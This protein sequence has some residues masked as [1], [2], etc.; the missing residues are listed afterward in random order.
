MIQ[1]GPT[2]VNVLTC[3]GVFGDGVRD[4]APGLQAALDSGAAV[5]HLPRP[6]AHYEVRRTLRLHSGQTLIAERQTVIRLAD[7][8]DTVLL[9]N[10]DQETG[11]RDVTVIGGVWDGNHAH[12][13][14][15]GAWARDQRYDPD[16]F[17]GVLV[18]FNRVCNLTVRELTLKDPE[19]FGMQLGNLH[20][21]TITDL[22]FDYN[23][24]R[25]NMDGVHLHGH[26]Y[27]GRIANLRGT[28]NDDLV[29][30]NADDGGM[31]EM[32]RGP[33][34]DITVD[35]LYS[36]NG[37]TGVRLLSAGSPV[38]RVRL[39]NV[40]GT[41]RYNVVSFTHHNVHPGAPSVFEDI[42][43]DGV[44]CAKPTAALP[45]PLPGDEWGRTSTPLIW[46][47][48]GTY[49]HN[50]SISR[51]YRTEAFARAPDTVVVDP[52][53]T[54]ERL[55]LSDVSQ[56]NRT[57]GPLTVLTNRGTIKVLQMTDVAATAVG[58][59]ARGAILRN[60]GVIGHQ[61]LCGLAGENLE[62]LTVE[63]PVASH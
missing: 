37:Y 58:G 62:A 17:I 38:R 55:R 21:F 12:Q 51:L 46:F 35:G 18:R 3:P 36:E 52:G 11:N 34:E 10:A 61:S 27:Q 59:V 49:C 6:A 33:I 24:A 29:A 28:T 1:V 47:A 25:A 60:E 2:A 48:A 63:S 31:Y 19:T 54:V 7:G 39:S 20:G 45:Q 56:L 53:A 13:S 57:P 30:L 43:I 5:V 14:P 15:H 23:L 9:A 16:Q 44:F 22:V 8:A 40:F 41:F 4:D 42:A 26:C 32:V 50:A